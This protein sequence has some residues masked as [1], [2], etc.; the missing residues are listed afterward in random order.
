MAFDGKSAG[1]KPPAP[2]TQG[3]QKPDPLIQPALANALRLGSTLAK[4]SPAGSR[5]GAQDQGK[6]SKGKR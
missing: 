4:M 5:A 2:P 3:A 6:P 1:A